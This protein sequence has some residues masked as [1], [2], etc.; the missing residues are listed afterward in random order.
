MTAR[1]N[2]WV[3]MVWEASR[4]GVESWA[5]IGLRLGKLAAGGAPAQLEAQRMVSEK[6]AAALDAQLEV[7]RLLALGRGQDAPM[8]ILAD[9]QAR[10]SAN[11]RRLSTTGPRPRT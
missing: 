8:R 9:Y 11:R 5:V 2:P 3:T 1:A 7:A 10:V 4:L 6:V